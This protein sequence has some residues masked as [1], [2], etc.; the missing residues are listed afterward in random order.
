MPLTDTAIRNAKPKDKP[1]KLSDGS[2]LYLLI[3]P[4][5]GRYWRMDYRFAEKRK[6]L[7][8]GVYPEVSLQAAR[9]ARAAAR[10]TLSAGDDPAEVKRANERESRIRAE[11]SFETVALEWLRAQQQKWTPR[12]ADHVSKRLR[13]DI[14]PALGKRPIA[15]IE[16][17]QLLDVLRKVEQCGALEIAKRLRQTCSQIFRY[18]IA[19]G[20]AKRDPAAD[21]IGAMKAKGRVQ[22]FRAMPVEELPG[23]LAAL[24]AY[25]GEPRTRLALKLMVLTFVRTTELRAAQWQEFEDLEGEA[26]L[27]R[28]PAE[29]MKMRFAHLVPLSP[30]AVA[31]LEELK[32]LCGNSPYLFPSPSAERIM[33]NNTMLYALYRMGYHSRATVH[34]FRALASTTLHEMGFPSDWIERQL[35]HDERDKVRAAYN[36]AQYLTERRRM[37]ERW[38]GFILSK[39]SDS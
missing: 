15:E 2:G 22:H 5:G 32:P 4:K 17:P 35:A 38:G 16:A 25:D 34:G 20:R 12:Y 9:K 39:T 14:F 27:W 19:T 18:A 3:H 21:L 28:I 11:N 13:A 8:L 36:H 33:S 30:P 31:V 24:E 26:P 6:T 29:R 10:E 23:F 7:S 1:Y 37:M